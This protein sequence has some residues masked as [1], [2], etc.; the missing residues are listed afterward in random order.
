[1]TFA[2]TVSLQDEL[3]RITQQTRM[4]VQPE[5]LAISERASAELLASGIESRILP[6]GAQAPEFALPD[7]L[8]GKLVRST[9]LLALGPLVIKFF[10][11]RWCPYCITELETWR[12]LHAQV[13][14]LDALLVA[15][16]PQNRR[17]NDFTIQQHELPFPVLSDAGAEVAAQ[18]GIAYT[19]TEEQRRYYESILVNIPFVNSGATYRTGT[20]ASWRLPLP[21][22]FVL[23]QDGVVAFAEAHADFRVRPEPADVMAALTRLRAGETLPL[24]IDLLAEDAWNQIV[25]GRDIRQSY[26]AVEVTAK[27]LK[28]RGSKGKARD[29]LEAY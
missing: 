25:A 28:E 27:Y 8:T 2:R 22:T 13:R 9:D 23:A 10:R 15:I 26:D 29:E 11:G 24:Y 20:E 17:H 6:A 19:V 7:A 18:F 14:G 12:D 3:D 1:M 5:R 4:L 21:A 16:S